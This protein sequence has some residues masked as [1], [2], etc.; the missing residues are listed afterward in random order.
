MPNDKNTVIFQSESGAIELK[1][2]ILNDTVLLTQ[3]Q[4]AN[5]FSVNKSAIS[6]HIKNI[7]ES[8]ELNK[9]T[10]VSILETVQLEGKRSIKRKIEY[11][12][13]DLV[14]SIGYRVNSIKATKFRQW[15]TLILRSHIK[16]GFTLNKNRIEENQQRLLSLIEE[17]KVIQESAN[18][19]SIELIQFFASTWFSL[20]AFDANDFAPKNNFTKQ[21][22]VI[23]AADLYSELSIFKKEL[24]VSDL[25]ATE[26]RPNALQGIVG[27]VWQSFSGKDVYPSI[28]EKVVH[29]FYFIV[30]DH[31]FFDGNK[32]CGAFIFIWILGK[33]GILNQ[34]KLS[35]QAL[36][37]ITLLVAQS[38]PQDK[39]RIIELL[40][41]LISA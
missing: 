11:Y 41:M 24:Q 39:D 20:K 13:L 27:N 36:T 8:K 21:D 14:I 12:N 16:H 6:K 19:G 18:S 30:K 5:I 40:L 33:T 31:P 15:A 38:K 22:L 1:V 17:L 23:T 25:F 37:V 3:N 26:M 29:L 9:E 28:E 10:T 4:V 34:F 2:D 32:R 35:P 7:F